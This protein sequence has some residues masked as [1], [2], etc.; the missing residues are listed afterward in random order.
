MLER[1]PLSITNNWFEVKEK[2]SWKIIKH[3]HVHMFWNHL[4]YHTHFAASNR[5]NLHI[6][7]FWLLFHLC[8]VSSHRKMWCRRN[9]MMQYWWKYSENENIA[10][11]T[12][13]QSSGMSN[14]PLRWKAIVSST[15]LWV[16]HKENIHFRSVGKFSY[17][18]WLCKVT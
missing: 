1:V 7:F 8:V 13:L 4:N 18:R 12:A 17:P 16:A 6:P 11:I 9:P 2:H 15:N 5:N 10:R 14:I 3:M